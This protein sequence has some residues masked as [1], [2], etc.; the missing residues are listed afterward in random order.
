VNLRGDQGHFDPDDHPYVHGE[1]V[2]SIA[3]KCT[4]ADIRPTSEV[5]AMYSIAKNGDTFGPAWTEVKTVDMGDLICGA[6]A[7]EN[8]CFV[9]NHPA[10]VRLP[11][12]KTR[13]K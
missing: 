12:K 3:E 7:R 10:Q 1:R 9:V 5:Y 11:R 8:I 13:G 6:V 4:L 2:L